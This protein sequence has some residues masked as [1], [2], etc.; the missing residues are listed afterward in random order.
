MTDQELKTIDDMMAKLPDGDWCAGPSR[1]SQKQMWDVER[2]YALVATC[3]RQQ[4]AEYI[5]QTPTVIQKLLS[6]VRFLRGQLTDLCEDSRAAAEVERLRE[7]LSGVL[8][9]TDEL[10]DTETVPHW[11]L[12]SRLWQ[13]R[14]IVQRGLK[15]VNNT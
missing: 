11:G 10:V 2:G 15:I 6:E 1:F 12:A 3:T 4:D 5:A 7:S 13:I 8:L 9:I 14:D